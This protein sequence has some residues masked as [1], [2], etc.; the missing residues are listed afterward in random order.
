VFRRARCDAE[1]GEFRVSR[2]RCCYVVAKNVER[3]VE[4]YQA[5]LGI[6]LAFRDG[7]KWV[8]FR[9]DSGNFAVSGAEEAAT[10]QSNSVIVFEV[11]DLVSAERTILEEGGL[12]L[13]RRDMNEHGRTVTFVDLDGNV[14]QVFFKAGERSVMEQRD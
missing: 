8:Q 5:L 10:P 9:T 14:G 11:G 4:F 2:V 12:I 6:P 13:N 7:S 3:S 1:Q